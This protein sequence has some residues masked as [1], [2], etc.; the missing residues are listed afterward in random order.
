M[1]SGNPPGTA[2]TS[3]EFVKQS[4]AFDVAY[5]YFVYKMEFDIG[6]ADHRTIAPGCTGSG[7]K[8]VATFIQFIRH[9][10]PENERR[11]YE[12]SKD[13]ISRH[14]L[15]TLFPDVDWVGGNLWIN[16]DGFA[17]LDPGRL[18]ERLRKPG[19]SERSKISALFAMHDTMYDSLLSC[20]LYKNPKG[21]TVYN[22][23]H[24]DMIQARRALS[25]SFKSLG[26]A[27]FGVGGVHLEN[28]GGKSGGPSGSAT[29]PKPVEINGAI[30][31][32]INCSP[33][34]ENNSFADLDKLWKKGQTDWLGTP[35]GR[36][37]LREEMM[38]RIA[39]SLRLTC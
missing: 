17:D 29:A 24:E 34:G 1:S 12:P 30:V 19:K 14:K 25:A 39:L 33:P 28:L 20:A 3:E 22:K 4:R 26:C 10:L 18:F 36:A 23:K 31:H 35:S 8:K 38:K 15:D 9:L 2:I 32:T 16:T 21:E 13:E 6:D 7:H 37:W 5:F 27:S 11:I